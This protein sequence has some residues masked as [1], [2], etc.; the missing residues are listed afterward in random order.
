MTAPIF[1]SG[2]KSRYDG[3]LTILLSA[4][5]SWRASCDT[6]GA[7]HEQSGPMFK[8]VRALL[9]PPAVILLI[10]MCMGFYVATPDDGRQRQVYTTARTAPTATASRPNETAAPR[11]S[12]VDN[13]LLAGVNAVTDSG[14]LP[15]AGAMAIPLVALFV[16]RR[17]A[18]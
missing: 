15:F 7:P 12:A 13:F 9:P 3:R 5:S 14:P 4:D 8:S 2:R 17:L 10:A 16:R 11:S 6:V 18:V 1:G